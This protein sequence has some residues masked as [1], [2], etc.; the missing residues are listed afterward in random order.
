MNCFQ[1]EFD[2]CSENQYRCSNGQCV[3]RGF[4]NADSY[5]LDCLDA[6]DEDQF[7]Q[8]SYRWIRMVK[9]HR[10]PSFTCEET[11][12]I[13]PSSGRATRLLL[14]S[15]LFTIETVSFQLSDA[16]RQTRDGSLFHLCCQ[17]M[18]STEGLR[19]L[20]SVL[21]S[22]PWC[23][24]GVLNEWNG[25]L[26][27]KGRCRDTDFHLLR[28]RLFHSCRSTD[29]LPKV[30]DCSHS[31]LS[32]CPN[33]TEFISSVTDQ[34]ICSPGDL[35][36]TVRECRFDRIKEIQLD[37]QQQQLIEMLSRD[38]CLRSSTARRGFDR[39]FFKAIQ[40][41]HQVQLSSETQ[42]LPSLS[43]RW[44]RFDEEFHRSYRYFREEKSKRRGQLV[45]LYVSFFS[46]RQSPVG[47]SDHSQSVAEDVS[48]TLCWSRWLCSFRWIRCV[49]VHRSTFVLD[50]S[51]FR[52]ASL[53]PVAT[54]KNVFP[55]IIEYPCERLVSLRISF[56]TLAFQTMLSD[57]CV[58]PSRSNFVSA[59]SWSRFT[60]GRKLSSTSFW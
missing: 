6:T 4:L 53:R 34:A 41:Y 35:N 46:F 54:E 31:S 23:P 3:P 43:I 24:F 22:S 51:F 1:L 10:D 26:G 58:K 19:D 42:F 25:T 8:V 37:R 47:P 49:S 15:S 7:H 17:S 36:D 16:L 38:L 12:W 18:W 29:R 48:T 50:V 14:S 21:F 20:S 57:F 44:G 9:C 39:S 33:S 32:F 60:S 13:V 59:T 27:Q 45:V 2:R 40:F 30:N 52:S 5:S 56:L 55:K 28:C 11:R